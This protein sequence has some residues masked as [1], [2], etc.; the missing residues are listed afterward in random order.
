[1]ITKELLIQQIQ[2][3]KEAA[4]QLNDDSK[5]NMGAAA[6]LEQL[7]PEFDKEEEVKQE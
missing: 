1:M 3:Y 4:Q 5:A 7:L 6:A 2:K